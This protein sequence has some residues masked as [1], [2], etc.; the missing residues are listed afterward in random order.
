[1]KTKYILLSML[2]CMILI[3][4][5]SFAQKQ[6]KT[7]KKVKVIKKTVDKEGNEKIEEIETEGKDINVIMEEMDIELDVDVQF[8][9]DNGHKK[10]YIK[11]IVDG[12]EPQIIEWEGDGEIPE[13]IIILMDGC[14]EGEEGTH[15][16]KIIDKEIEEIIVDNEERPFLGVLLGMKKEVTNENGEETVNISHDLSLMD[17][18]EGGPAEQAGL[19]SKDILKSIDNNSLESYSDLKEVMSGYNIGDVITVGYE[20]SGEK[21]STELTLASSQNF[22]HRKHNIWKSKDGKMTAI[23]GDQKMLIEEEI[24]EEGD[25]K[26]IIRVIKHGE[27]HDDA[28]HKIVIIKKAKKNEEGETEEDEPEIEISVD[29]DYQL[30][31]EEFSLFPNPTSGE[32]NVA[33]RA[34]AEPTDITITDISGKEIYRKNLDGFDG[35][36]NETVQVNN[37]AKGVLILTVRQGNKVFA[38]SIVYQ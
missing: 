11:K 8:D 1:M 23:M 28:K 22:A 6:N 9:E 36:F 37:A 18:I 19:Q 12:G 20:R 4:N 3:N 21:M 24:I 27:S 26:K 25:G 7:D 2:A 16:V 31:L 5:N 38:E 14:E 33:F 35:Y 10:I 17:V 29:P 13:D 34:A 32:I 15:K 30:T